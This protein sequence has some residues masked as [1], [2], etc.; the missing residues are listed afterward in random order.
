[1]SKSS[2]YVY[3]N[4][5]VTSGPEL[6]YGMPYGH[7]MVRLHDGSIMLIGGYGNSNLNEKKSVIFNP[8]TGN[9]S[10]GPDMI[11]GRK[12]FGIAVINR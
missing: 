11:Y 8:L 5:S 7:A 9:F 3:A 6:P 10:F 1:M 2:I 12:K 4:G